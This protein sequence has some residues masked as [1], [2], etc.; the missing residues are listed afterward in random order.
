[1]FWHTG[2]LTIMTAMIGNSYLQFLKLFI[3][4]LVSLQYSVDL[5]PVFTAA[6]IQEVVDGF[7]I[8]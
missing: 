3:I 1:M 6:G 7:S 2:N 5:L 8:S 4:F